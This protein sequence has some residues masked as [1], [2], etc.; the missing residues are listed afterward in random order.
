MQK[1]GNQFE[2]GSKPERATGR[3]SCGL[4]WAARVRMQS[5]GLKRGSLPFQKFLKHAWANFGH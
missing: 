1:K 3:T 2:I 4:V 5:P